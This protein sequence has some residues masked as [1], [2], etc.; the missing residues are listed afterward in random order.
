MKEII[1]ASQSPYRKELLERLK[2]TFKCVPANIDEESIWKT[3]QSPKQVA[4][5]LASFLQKKTEEEHKC[6]SVYLDIS[7]YIFR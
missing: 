7:C 4:E 2:V 3:I 5:K 6:V 1:L